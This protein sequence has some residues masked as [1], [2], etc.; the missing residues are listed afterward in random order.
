M[1]SNWWPWSPEEEAE[2]EHELRREEFGWMEEL[3]DHMVNDGLA[4]SCYD[5]LQPLDDWSDQT[6]EVS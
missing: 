2:W 5:P 1:S 6:V 3:I 4:A